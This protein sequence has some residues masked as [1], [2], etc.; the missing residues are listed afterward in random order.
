MAKSQLKNEITCLVLC[1]GR[2]AKNFLI[3]LLDYYIKKGISEFEHIQIEDFGG[4]TQLTDSLG[5]WKNISGF[6][7]NVK[8][9]C[10]IRDAEADFLKSCQAIRGSLAKNQFVAPKH[11]WTVKEKNG[12]KLAYI[13]FPGTKDSEGNYNSGTLEDLCLESL[14]DVDKNRK[15]EAIDAFIDKAGKDFNLQFPRLHKTRLHEFL[16]M[17][18]KYVDCKIGEA[19]K[20]GA[21]DFE[22]PVVKEIVRIFK[23]LIK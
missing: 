6:R 18:D 12:F 20:A 19:A 21:F 2:D 3:W 8:S 16:V 22:N 7:E 1:E 4:I 15:L 9:L 13:V 5:V 14:A 11:A 10:I 23:E 17:H